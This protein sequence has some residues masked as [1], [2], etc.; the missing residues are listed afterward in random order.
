VHQK[1]TMKTH[2]NDVEY[3]KKMAQKGLSSFP[4]AIPFEKPAEKKSS[5][6]EDEKDKFKT[7]DVK[8]DKN[9]DNSETIEYSI[10]VFE[11]GTPE[12][13]VQW[14]ESYKELEAM[15]PLEKPDHKVNVIRNLLKGTY[16][17]VFNTN[18]GEGNMTEKKVNDSLAKVSLKA[19]NNDRHAYRRQVQYMRYQLYFTTNNFKQF[20]HRL[21]QLNKYLKYF[22]IPP[23]KRSVSALPE[24]NLIEIIDNSKPL[25][26]HQQMLQNNYD[27]YDKDLE[28]FVQYIERLE[29]SAKIASALS[30]NTSSSS[31]SKKKRKKSSTDTEEKEENKLHK[32][33][34]C[35]RMVTHKSDNCWE[36]PGNEHLKPSWLKRQKTSESKK[37]PSFTSEQVNFL[38]Q[39]A[40]LA[41]NKNRKSKQIKKRKVTYKEQSESESD[42]HED[43]NA[44]DKLLNDVDENSL[45]NSSSSDESY[46]NLYLSN[47]RLNKRRKITHATSEVVG[48]IADT[49]NN[50]TR[51]LRVLLDS[52]TSAT[53][54]LR[55][56]IAK[57]SRYKHERVKWNTMGG[58]F[59]TRKK[60]QISFKLVEF[61][62]NKVINWTV[63]V[64]DQTDPTKAKYDMIIGSDLLS[65]LKIDLLYSQ[66]QIVWDEVVVPMKD[67]GTISSEEL[68]QD[69]YEM[70]KDSTIIQ[71]SEER[72]NE[73]IKAMYGKVSIKDHVKTLKHLS[74]PQQEELIKV[75]KAYPEMYEGAIGT[76]NIAP[77]H[78]ELKKD[79]QPYHTRPFPVPKAYESL[80]KEECR[81]FEDA[82][83]WHHT[84]D[85]TWAA[86]SFIV[87]KK[88]GDVRVVTDF[89]ELNKWIVRKPYPLPKILDILQKMEKFKFATA[90]DLR[91]G[92]YHI[93]L[94]KATQKL[95]TTVLP[96]G[97]YSYERLPM[98]I[99]TSPDIFQKAM[100]DI[101]GDLDY[102]LVYLDDILILSN[103][104]DTF[105]QHLDKVKTVFARL[106][107]MGMKVNL[108]KTEFFKQELEYLG[109]LLTPH[110]IKPLPKKVEA[111]TRILPP[112][113]KRQ[114][115]RFLGMV[116]Y[117]RDMWKRRSHILAP[118]SKLISQKVKW[119]WGEEEQKAFEEAKRM[120]KQETMLA[121]PKFNEPFHIYT[122]ASDTQ[123]GGVIMQDN[124]PLAFYTRKMNSAQSNYSTGEQELLSIVETLK[125]FENIL[126]GQRLIVH[127][128]H[129]NLLYRKL[130]SSRL[131]RWRMLIEEYGPEF[132]H[133]KGEK[134]VVA[135]AL[136]RLQ[137]TPKQHDELK[138]EPEKDQMSYVT[139]E[140]IL[141]EVFPMSPKE[142]FAHQQKDKSLLSKL[143]DDP[144]YHTVK[145]EG[146]HLIHY[147]EK[148]VVPAT[149]KERVM[150]WFHTYLVHPGSTRMLKTIQ[151]TMYWSKMREDIDKYVKTC[152]VC[153]LT[154]KQRKK[155]GHLPAKQAEVKPW[156]R[157]NVDL[158]GPYTIKTKRKSYEL[159][160][161]TMI[162][163]ATSWFEI[164]RIH[165]KSSEEAQRIFD[166]TWLARYPRPKEIGFD[167]GG[168][169][170][171]LFRELCDNMGIKQKPTT[172]YNPQS[173]AVLERIHQVLG[174]QLRSFEL[175][176]RPLT[177]EE[178]TFEPFLTA[179]A[180]AIRCT[181]HTTL[182]AT[183]GQL[184]FG[185]D[186][187]LPVKFN[188][189]WA[190][191]AQR[192]QDQ[193]DSSNRAENSKRIDYTYKVGDKVL[194]TKPGILRKLATPRTGPFEV[195]QVFSNGTINIR[196]GA[197]I[198]RV[199][200]RR[201][202]PFH[203]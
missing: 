152:E 116:N 153:Q 112:K 69:I 189:D 24:E 183:P 114:L 147:K 184:V 92:Y 88:T 31:S 130:A 16:L 146:K 35:K 23:G 10:K 38:I 167:N 93:P 59:V 98:G 198:Q 102:V 44:I 202:S 117:Y 187:I 67:R 143:K 132:R 159:R 17:E 127:T 106:H 65:E 134:N 73:I 84:L 113:T 175:E 41:K 154:K 203:E 18:L 142:L 36:K 66:Q 104:E 82:K 181:Y 185:R 45:T 190:L 96:W 42:N 168:E 160:A 128:D 136:S 110:G 77:V 133:I 164:A 37:T 5:N 101:F 118:L 81:R 180:Y 47:H 30:K 54:V 97:K 94:D 170:K 91:K 28:E 8:I 122:D 48:E 90:V 151:S 107:H 195:Q 125:Q 63:H 27:P 39:N 173:N 131:V 174:N 53:I 119:N 21:K 99:A 33:K 12:T 172:D 111:I 72:H 78:F 141:E 40:H 129:L 52:G 199:N 150:Y 76:L 148:I 135:D 75:L 145:V 22:P 176:D 34:Y 7:F 144:L 80:T 43:H 149:L 9:D 68:L 158:I 169:F 62:H 95:C 124:K 13:Y 32:C 57:T 46:L 197:I 11:E 61:S 155:Y 89:R 182:Q 20:E 157:V 186:M 2:Y 86:P 64:D 115:R 192:K 188:A 166:S 200:I 83:I 140:D 179:C 25:E 79:A 51:P 3:A 162:D 161:M 121:Y 137:M 194:L 14:Y 19:F 56:F 165:T 201:V 85:S 100:N 55:P 163:P 156:K 1:I 6:S 178:L 126:M 15:M 139:E 120:I 29:A 70:T 60:A 108:Q 26:Y 58:Q 49:A 193:I 109:Y 74:Q 87:P 50:T 171:Q 103:D 4:P 196:R 138:W 123:L 177:K 105:A 191:I 71:M